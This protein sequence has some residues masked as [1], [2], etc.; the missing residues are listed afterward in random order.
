MEQF[1]TA[2]ASVA[3][4]AHA[5]PHQH[6]QTQRDTSLFTTDLS[7]SAAP[8][9]GGASIPYL[10]QPARSS[11]SQR[12]VQSRVVSAQ[13]AEPVAP[14]KRKRHPVRA[15]FSFLVVAS[16]LGGAGFTSWYFLI[17][18][19]VAWAQDVAPLATFVEETTHSKFIEDVPVTTLSVPEYE[20]KLGIDVLA[21]SYSDA[22]G[23]FGTLRAVGL[24]SGVPEPSMVGHIAAVAMTAFYSSTDKTIYRMDGRTPA[25]DLATLRALTVALVDQNLNWS[26]DLA[27][28]TDAQQVGIRAAVDGVGAEVVRAM[29]AKDPQLEAL[30]AYEVQSR[31]AAVGIA[32]EARPTYLTAVLGSYFFG[33]HTSPASK[34]D[35]LLADIVMPS[36]D[37]PMFDPSRSSSN[38]AVDVPPPNSG[39]GPRTLGMQFWYLALLP[40]IGATDARAAALTWAGDSAVTTTIQGRAC[41]AATITTLDAAANSTMTSALQRWAQSLPISSSAVISNDPS[42]LIK[43]SVCEPTEP[44][45]QVTGPADATLLY[46]A[47]MRE[48]DI[49]ENLIRMG[50]PET[51]GPWS[52][53][54]AVLRTGGLAN[55]VEGSTDPLQAE[56]MSNVLSYCKNA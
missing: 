6:P 34:P 42:T 40:R 18:K 28:L 7:V 48:Q 50:L 33:A 31:T 4:L 51:Q 1:Q 30:V 29:F 45:T 39:E 37:A 3:L 43:V 35:R 56:A 5:Q 47:P 24:V 10:G 26:K 41:L 23:R 46:S 55:F 38:A 15:F 8:S 54:I 32:A 2:T 53:A 20:V 14:K 12:V 22:D 13:P 19:K 21:R 27:T 36:S 17:N 25:F 52:C 9:L 11:G 44:S 16:L 49:G